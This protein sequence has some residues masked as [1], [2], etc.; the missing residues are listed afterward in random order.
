MRRNYNR[1]SA[2][3]T[4]DPMG[5]HSPP[6][7]DVSPNQIILGGNDPAA[8]KA[9]NSESWLQPIGWKPNHPPTQVPPYLPPPYGIDGLVGRHIPRTQGEPVGNT[10]RPYWY[11]SEMNLPVWKYYEPGFMDPLYAQ[12]IRKPC[13]TSGSSTV[14]KIPIVA[15]P[16]FRPELVHRGRGQSFQ[17]LFDTDPCPELW[18]AYEKM[19]PEQQAQVKQYFESDPRGYCFPNIPEFEPVLY[20]DK[21]MFY[22]NS[23]LM[24]EQYTNLTSAKPTNQYKDYAYLTQRPVSYADNGSGYS[25]VYTP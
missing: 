8:Y 23:I 3:V 18:T 22:G 5:K 1:N 11:P 10:L 24:K 25:F 7:R 17:R 4:A 15:T 16:M 9:P 13:Q 6:V 21:S 19:T 2:P 14:D 20:T 12:Y